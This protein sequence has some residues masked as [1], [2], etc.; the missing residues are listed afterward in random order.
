MTRALRCLAAVLRSS[1]VR[2]Q[3]EPLRVIRVPSV[4]D[5]NQRCRD[6]PDAEAG[7]DNRFEYTV[8]RGQQRRKRSRSGAEDNVGDQE[9]HERFIIVFAR[10]VLLI[11]NTPRGMRVV[12]CIARRLINDNS[13]IFLG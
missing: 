8:D 3:D 1:A 10:R 4:R 7:W 2:Y 5:L 9:L 12:A 13:Q 11:T 6:R